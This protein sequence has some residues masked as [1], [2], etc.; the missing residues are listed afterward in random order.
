MNRAGAAETCAATEFRTDHLQLLADDPEQRRIVGR[1][2][3]HIP[4]VDIEIWHRVSPSGVG[5][6]LRRHLTF[7]YWPAP[8]GSMPVGAKN[9]TELS[10][11]QCNLESFE[12]NTVVRCGR[13]NRRHVTQPPR[14]RRLFHFRISQRRTD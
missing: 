4:S 14:R 9:D 3:G 13:P 1:L 6:R 8:T 12:E 7:E 2:D 5:G 10:R 11:R